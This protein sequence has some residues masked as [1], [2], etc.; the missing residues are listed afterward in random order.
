MRASPEVE[1]RGKCVA[2]KSFKTYKN[3]GIWLPGRLNEGSLH[4]F[5]LV[6]VAFFVGR[7]FV[8]R[9]RECKNAKMSLVL[10]NIYIFARTSKKQ[11]TE[12]IFEQQQIWPP[13]AGNVEVNKCHW[14]LLI[15]AFSPKPI[16]KK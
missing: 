8:L 6:V 12:S 3:E 4:N 15:F 11:H 14:S 5:L 7:D 10:A 13:R 1:V 9:E 2:R 16:T